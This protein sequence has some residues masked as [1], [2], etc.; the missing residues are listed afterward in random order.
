MEKNIKHLP[1]K[2]KCL[3]LDLSLN[4]LGENADSEKILG[5][6]LKQLPN[7]LHDLKLDL[8]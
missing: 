8:S 7:N 3:E 2:L 1:N 4:R 6:I 5:N